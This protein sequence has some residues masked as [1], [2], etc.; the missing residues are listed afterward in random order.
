M[1]HSHAPPRT[2]MDATTNSK[3]SSTVYPNVGMRC[4][5]TPVGPDELWVAD[6]T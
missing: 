2:R 3:H 1:G 5:I 6:L 4:S